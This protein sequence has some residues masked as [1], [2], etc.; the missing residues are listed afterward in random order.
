MFQNINE[1]TIDNVDYKENKHHDEY[2]KWYFSDGT[3]VETVHRHRFYNV[4]AQAFKYMDEW[5]IGDHGYNINGEEIQLIKHENVKERVQHCTLFT[6]KYNNYFAN[7]M[8]SGNR[9]SSEIN[10]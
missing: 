10:L 9:N 2:D 1:S 3:V 6:E 8:L 7:G 4:E 5:N